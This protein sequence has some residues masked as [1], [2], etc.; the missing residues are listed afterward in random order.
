METAQLVG[1]ANGCHLTNPSSLSSSVAAEKVSFLWVPRSLAAA[2]KLPTQTDATGVRER[3]EEEEDHRWR[4]RRRRREQQISRGSEAWV[5]MAGRSRVSS[6]RREGGREGGSEGGSDRSG[7]SA[8]GGGGV[9]AGV[10][11][12]RRSEERRVGKECSW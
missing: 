10:G 5:A 6:A 9:E 7:G 11:E 8:G 4:R 3:E 1:W 12:E 2:L